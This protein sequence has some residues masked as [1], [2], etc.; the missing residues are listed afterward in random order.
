MSDLMADPHANHSPDVGL[1]WRIRIIRCMCC[2]LSCL[3]QL[4]APTLIF[5][6]GRVLLSVPQQEM[7]KNY[8]LASQITAAPPGEQSE[9]WTTFFFNVRLEKEGSSV[10]KPLIVAV[11][12]LF[13]LCS[14]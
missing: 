2:Q 7:G 8:L 9:P 14:T 5:Q 10:Q 1:R 6:G 3:R 4:A 13:L 12:P 11:E